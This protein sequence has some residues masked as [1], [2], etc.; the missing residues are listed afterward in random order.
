M[1]P[2]LVAWLLR[3]ALPAWLAPDYVV[4]VGV[5]GLL[6][7]MVAL[8]LAERDG[9]VVSTQARAL[10][11]G[12]VAA[13]LGG[14]VFEAL[15]ALPAALA[16]G[17]WMPILGAGR[18]ARRRAGLHDLGQLTGATP[19]RRPCR[20]SSSSEGASGAGCRRARAGS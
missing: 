10:A 14:Y 18:A 9:A 5:A 19:R 13:L 20:P 17:S 8:R 16:E 1:R 2:T 15:R 7:A 3:H 6:G 4:L 12:Y 11:L